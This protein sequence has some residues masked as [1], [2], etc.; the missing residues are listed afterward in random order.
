MLGLK[1]EFREEA[2]VAYCGSSMTPLFQEGDKLLIS[3]GINQSQLEPGDILLLKNSDEWISHRLVDLNG[4]TYLKG[5]WAR[6]L[7]KIDH[8]SIWGVVVGYS[9]KNSAI[10]WGTKGQ[11]L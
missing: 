2:Y 4:K 11:R 6:E 9:R 1:E 5:D 7:E 8:F 3:F 10:R